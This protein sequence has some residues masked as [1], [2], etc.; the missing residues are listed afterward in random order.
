MQDILLKGLE[1]KA[2]KNDWL[3]REISFGIHRFGDKKKEIFYAELSILFSAGVDI[4]SILEIIQDQL[5]N[6]RD[7]ALI[8]QLK[9]KV[10]NGLGI[11]EA[12]QQSKKFSTYEFYSMKIGEET[13]KLKEVLLELSKFYSNKIKLRRQVISALTYPAIVLTTA[14]GVLFFM[15]KFIVPMFAQVFKRFNSDLPPLTKFVL[16]VS[17]YISH[18]GIYMIALILILLFFFTFKRKSPGFEKFKSNLLMKLPIL[19]NLFRKIYLARFCQSMQLLT[20]SKTQLVESLRLVREMISFYPLQH[21]IELVE[22]DTMNGMPLHLA[23]AK[24]PIF[25]RRF[26]SM[27]KV[28]EEVNKLELVF[29]NLSDTY[30]DEIEHQTKILGSLVEPILILI[31]G[32]IVGFILVSMY[33]PL[34]KLGV[35]I[36]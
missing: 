34:F 12:M 15:M 18:S 31:L 29:G 26:V 21:A 11:W 7:K 30:S 4:K 20:S 10:V 33:L 19:G 9:D 13:G 27:V 3:Q 6:S 2:V 32:V 25:E 22:K 14:F 16:R 24:H 28:G 35:S 5:L 8:G 17:E 23:F 1:A 36:Q